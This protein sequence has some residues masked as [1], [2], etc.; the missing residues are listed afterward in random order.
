[1]GIDSATVANASILASLNPSWSL[2]ALALVLMVG[3]VIWMLNKNNLLTAD[4]NANSKEMLDT[5][6]QIR[7][8]QI[9]SNQERKIQTM[10]LDAIE[11]V[12]SKM[13]KRLDSVEDDI[14]DIKSH[15]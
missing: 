4:S 7:S 11:Q 5:V 9:V 15:K 10:R 12:Q 3:F 13:L 6:Q 8:D 14:E 1:M 2:V